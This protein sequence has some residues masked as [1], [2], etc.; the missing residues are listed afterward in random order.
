MAKVTLAREA[1][2]G[3]DDLPLAIHSRA[4]SLLERLASWP[5]VSGAKP[6]TGRW[7]EDTDFAREII[8]CNSAS[9]GKR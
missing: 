6:L 8:A 1:A 7:P 5:A 9:K 3:L 4:L 2:E